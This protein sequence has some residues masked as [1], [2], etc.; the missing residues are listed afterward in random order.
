MDLT[1]DAPRTALVPVLAVLLV[2]EGLPLADIPPGAARIPVA[3]EL[4]RPRVGVEEGLPD[5]IGWASLPVGVAGLA[6]IGVT[7]RVGALSA[8][9]CRV[10]VDG[11][12]FREARI[13]V[14]VDD[15][16][17]VAGWVLLAV[18]DGTRFCD[19]I[20]APTLRGLL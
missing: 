6:P 2:G 7:G 1:S 14:G 19:L 20:A 3:L 4:D 10:G 18:L 9:V 16:V 8:L 11:R 15:L 5:E 13:V 17:G 12:G